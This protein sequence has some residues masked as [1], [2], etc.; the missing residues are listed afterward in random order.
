MAYVRN[1]KVEN[2]IR[3]LKSYYYTD[4][5]KQKDGSV[6]FIEM[7][8]IARASI[9]ARKIKYEKLKEF[10]TIKL[11]RLSFFKETYDEFV[12]LS[13][14][15]GKYNVFRQNAIDLNTY[16]DTMNE[17]VGKINISIIDLLR[18]IRSN[19]REHDEISK[20]LDTINSLLDFYD[21][22]VEELD[23]LENDINS[24]E[25]LVV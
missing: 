15:E 18:N 3:A 25:P 11:N 5:E 4:G 14:I 13:Q 2:Y 10:L 24:I 7:I 1:E 21:S 9:K 16:S 20:R 22:A 6:T 23:T 19:D 17:M 12:D 8:T